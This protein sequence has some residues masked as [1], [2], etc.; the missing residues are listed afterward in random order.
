MFCE[1]FPS[2][3][4]VSEIRKTVTV[5]VLSV[6]TLDTSYEG[7]TRSFYMEHFHPGHTIVLL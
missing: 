6:P 5:I 3:H 7:C 1:I 4:V 2:K